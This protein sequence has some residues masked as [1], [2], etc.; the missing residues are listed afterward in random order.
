MKQLTVVDRINL[1]FPGNCRDATVR[2]SPDSQVWSAESSSVGNF[3]GGSFV[4]K[5]GSSAGKLV[6]KI[7]VGGVSS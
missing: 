6:G 4:G 3:V 2:L 1:R 7:M 5:D